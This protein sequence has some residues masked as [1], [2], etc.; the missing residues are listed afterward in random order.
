[1]GVHEI[2][3]FN[4]IDSLP[5]SKTFF[6]QF[7]AK[8]GLQT[9]ET[10]MAQA[11]A[12]KDY[13]GPMIVSLLSQV[14]RLKN[15]RDR[16][17]PLPIRFDDADKIASLVNDFE[18]GKL[19]VTIDQSEEIELIR[20][21]YQVEFTADQTLLRAVIDG[22]IKTTRVPAEAAPIADA[23]TAI[24]VRDILIQAGKRCRVTD[25]RLRI[26]ESKLIKNLAE[27]GFEPKVEE[28]EV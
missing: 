3:L 5:A 19:H 23:R 18:S 11:K 27:V 7:C 4:D 16:M 17:A 28:V 14:S 20:R 26:A 22:D 24:A 6:V 15:F 13:G 9:S 8:S 12:G 25:G 2:K 21:V 10:R 1:M